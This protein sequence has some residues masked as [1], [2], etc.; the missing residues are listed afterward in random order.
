MKVYGLTG[1]I[2]SGKS[3]VSKMLRELGA[4]VLDADQIAREVVEPGQP[5]LGEIALR[6]PGVVGPDG[7][8][9]RAKLAARVFGDEAE[10]K[11]LNA[12]VHPRIQAEVLERTGAL[13]AKG[14][15]QVFYDA[16][17]LIENG[18]DRA[19]SGVILV[20]APPQVQLERLLARGA[21]PEEAQARVAAQLPLEAKAR[22]ATWIIDNSGDLEHT[23]AQVGAVWM[24]IR[25]G[26]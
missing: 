23:R 15:E 9:D 14:V 26:R 8:L 4:V 19:M 24:S 10:R 17:L 16:A 12:I 6:F 2:A 1:G 25:E 7:R 3:T 18:L 5:A 22:H 20:S 13:A 11:A 21:T